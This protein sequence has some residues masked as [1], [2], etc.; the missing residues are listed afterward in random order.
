MAGGWLTFCDGSLIEAVRLDAR[1][2]MP[3]LR[4]IIC[5]TAVLY[6]CPDGLLRR[7]HVAVAK[8][9]L[10]VVLLILHNDTCCFECVWKRVKSLSSG[11]H[12]HD[13]GHWDRKGVRS[14]AVSQLLCP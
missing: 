7:R 10:S 9:S 1:W 4:V 6:S 12:L 3:V 2:T 11:K 8:N 13:L 14:V 5:R